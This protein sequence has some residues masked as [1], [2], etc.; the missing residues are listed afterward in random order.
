[1]I[2]SYLNKNG[3]LLTIVIP[4]DEGMDFVISLNDPGIVHEF[5]LGMSIFVYNKNS[6]I[7]ET[8]DYETLGINYNFNKG[9]KNE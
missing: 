6:G 8:E 4:L 1:M 7:Y 9:G 5:L 2:K 3:K